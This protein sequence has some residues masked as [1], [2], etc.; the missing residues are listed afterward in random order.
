[1]PTVEKA[2]FCYMFN[3]CAEQGYTAT[4]NPCSG[5]KKFTE[6]G[7]DAYVKDLTYK[8]VWNAADRPTPKANLRIHLAVRASALGT[9]PQRRLV[10]GS[11]SQARERADLLLCLQGRLP[12]S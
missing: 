1:M 4:P 6:R 9:R 3:E 10:T 8:A 7:R 11:V 2:L 12:M 5:P